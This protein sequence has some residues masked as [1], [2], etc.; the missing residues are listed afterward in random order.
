MQCNEQVAHCIDQ[1]ICINGKSRLQRSIEKC[2]T[3]C[4]SMCCLCKLVYCLINASVTNR[5]QLL[6]SSML[7]IRGTGEINNRNSRMFSFCLRPCDD[8]FLVGMI[9]TAQ[10]HPVYVMFG[11]LTNVSRCQHTLCVGCQTTCVIQCP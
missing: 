3:W 5:L 10:N 7:H 9:G 8:V 4:L 11:C 2:C 6:C 1:F